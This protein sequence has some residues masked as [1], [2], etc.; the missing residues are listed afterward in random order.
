MNV[1]FAELTHM[2]SEQHGSGPELQGLTSR[3]MSLGLVLNQV[4]STSVKPPT[5]ND[6]DVLFQLMFDEY[7]K[8]PSVVSTPNSAATLLPPNIA[9]TPSS[10]TIDKDAPSLSIS[11][12]NKTTSLPI[13]FTNVEQPH[14]EEVAEFDSDTYTN[15]FAPPV[16]ISAES[17]SRI[18][19]TSN[20]HTFQE[21][22]VN[23]KR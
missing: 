18:V 14:N 8:P 4:A 17:S 16:N 12:N 19:D 6:W 20:M 1:Q 23:N 15:P 13:N 21:P 7:F 9:R 22:H 2:A 3:H 10:N 11:P 5:K